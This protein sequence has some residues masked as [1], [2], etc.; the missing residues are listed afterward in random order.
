MLRNYLKIA[1]R[2]LI[3]HKLFT[4]INIGGMAI[5]MA[6]FLLIALFIYDELSFDKHVDDYDRKYR[7]YIE[8]FNDDGRKTL[9]AMVP[10]MVAPTLAAD[11]P[12]VESYFRFMNLN[13]PI[14]F[15]VGE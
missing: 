8:R 14:L 11:Y 4:W 12:E 15:Q 5:G 10:P 13:D 7:V 6:A 1:I 2:N 9:S 3:G